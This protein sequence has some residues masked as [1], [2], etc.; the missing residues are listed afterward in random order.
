M[1]GSGVLPEGWC[2]LFLGTAMRSKSGSSLEKGGPGS[3]PSSG[4]LAV[5]LFSSN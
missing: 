3:Q 5:A 4:T 1:E 2:A